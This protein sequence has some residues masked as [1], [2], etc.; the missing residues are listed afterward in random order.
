MN[1]GSTKASFRNAAKEQKE[2]VESGRRAF[3]KEIGRDAYVKG[4]E[5]AGLGTPTN[6]RQ[7][8]LPPDAKHHLDVIMKEFFIL[9]ENIYSAGKNVGG[10]LFVLKK[11]H[12]RITLDV[13]ETTAESE[14]QKD[15]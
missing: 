15:D 3:Y 14:M 1:K 13:D 6:P 12:L 5:E 9:A 10:N 11:G 4:Y 8:D 2:K 7:V